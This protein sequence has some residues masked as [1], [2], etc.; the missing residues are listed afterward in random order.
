MLPIGVDT[1]RV[2]LHVL[3]ATVWV[4]GQLVM[5]ALVP[6]LRGIAP[7]APRLAAARFGM[8]AWGAFAVL[9]FT[10]LW[11][12][13]VIRSFTGAYGT[14][15]MVKLV[16]VFLSGVFAFAH[17]RTSSAPVRGATAGLGLVASLGALLLGVS[18]PG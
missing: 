4:G 12:M 5:G 2:F 3:A 11:N 18:F 6:V 1:L 9:V 8:V 7:D 15:L 16:L 13:M 14:T 17:Q 10:G